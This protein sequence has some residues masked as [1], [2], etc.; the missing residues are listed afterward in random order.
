VTGGGRWA[1]HRW[2]GQRVITIGRL[3]TWQDYLVADVQCVL[4]VPAALSRSTAAQL[5]TNSLTA[6]LLVTS[7]PDVQ[8]GEW[9]LQTAAGSSGGRIVLQ[10]ARQRRRVRAGPRRNQ[11]NPSDHP[12]EWT[13]RST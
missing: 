10:L 5:L 6:M 1:A 13:R 8:P 4:P 9:L 11:T 7:E 12:L 2:H 3:G